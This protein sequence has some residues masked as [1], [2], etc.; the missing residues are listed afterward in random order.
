MIETTRSKERKK[1]S[2]RKRKRRDTLL[3]LHGSERL[4][5]VSS[6]IMFGIWAIQQMDEEEPEPFDRD[7]LSDEE[8]LISVML[9]EALIAIRDG[10]E[11]GK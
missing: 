1:V 11:V 10:L 6:G 3:R 9:A 8:V 2:R 4:R 5:K 7:S